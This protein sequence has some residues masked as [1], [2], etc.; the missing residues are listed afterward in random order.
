MSCPFK[1]HEL[2]Y[3][4]IGKNAYVVVKAIKYFCFYILNF[5]IVVL[6][7]NT[8]VKSILSQQD[9]G[10]KRG[11]W[12]AKIQEYDLEIRPTKLVCGR[13]LCQ[14]IFENIAKQYELDV[15]KDLPK[16]LFSS[17]ID[18]WYSNIAYFLTYGEC[19]QHLSFKEKRSIKLKVANFV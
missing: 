7:P 11:N 17:T 1:S 3:S 5:H 4:S 8:T 19:P 16:E 6:V 12:I 2:N 10:T 14:L 13:G 18:E 9:F 15:P